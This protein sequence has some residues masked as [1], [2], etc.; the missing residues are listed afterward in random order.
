MDGC[1]NYF[2][3]AKPDPPFKGGKVR[4]FGYNGK[5]LLPIL[6]GKPHEVHEALC[7]ELFGN[8]AIRQGKWKLVWAREQSKWELYDLE[9]DRTETNDLAKKYPERVIG[10]CI[11]N[12]P[13]AIAKRDCSSRVL[14][15]F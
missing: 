13:Q 11:V 10:S 5:S 12:D 6:E 4:V 15:S 14:L 9:A 3:P 7:W 1:C 8:R 2:D